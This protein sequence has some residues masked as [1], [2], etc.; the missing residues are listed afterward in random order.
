MTYRSNIKQGF[1]EFLNDGVFSNSCLLANEC[2]NY[3]MTWGCDI[4]CPVLQRGEC[5]LKD[6]DNKHLWEQIQDR[7]E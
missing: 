1:A 7:E 4:D 5:E 2:E 6:A 3:G